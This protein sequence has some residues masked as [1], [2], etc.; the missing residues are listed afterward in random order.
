EGRGV[1]GRL[2]RETA[3]RTP[4]RPAATASALVIGLAL[5]TLVAIFGASTKASVDHAVDRNTKADVVLKAR[6]FAGFSPVVAQRVA[7]LP[8]VEAV[9]PFQFRKVRINNIVA[10]VASAQADGLART[11]DLDVT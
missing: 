7:Q 9:S 4:R 1:T 6:Q 3:V 5:V 8:G 10:T 2:A 11:V